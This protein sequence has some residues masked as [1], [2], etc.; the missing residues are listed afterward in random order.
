[1]LNLI[2]LDQSLAS[3]GVALLKGTSVF[4]LTI[5]TKPDIPLYERLFYIEQS[6]SNLIDLVNPLSVFTEE[7]YIGSGPS[8]TSAIALVR[9]ETLIHLLCRRKNIPVV[10]VPCQT[11]IS[12]SWRALLG[13]GKEKKESIAF[14][15]DNFGIDCNE[16]E[17]DAF[18]ILASQCLGNGIIL[19]Q[20][21]I[22]RIAHDRKQHGQLQSAI[23]LL[24]MSDPI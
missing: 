23:D 2:A 10:A 16:H 15:R 24:K 13:I 21:K 6:I 3:T 19:Q 11:R 14:V 17:A 22:S 4:L 20:C 9:V 8:R 1:M 12:T 7:M 18:C 5:K